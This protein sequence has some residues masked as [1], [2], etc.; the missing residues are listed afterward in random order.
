MAAKKKTKKAAGKKRTAAKKKSPA[1]KSS[2]PDDVYSR[3]R[4]RHQQHGSRSRFTSLEIGRTKLRVVTFHHGKQECAFEANYTHFNVPG[5]RK[6]VRCPGEEADCPIC[7]LEAEVPD[8][9]WKGDSGGRGGI[10]PSRRFVCNAVIRKGPNQKED[11]L[12]QMELPWMV[13]DKINK[14][15]EDGE[16][17][18]AFDPKK[19]VDFH[20]TRSGTGRNTK[21]EVSPVMSSQPVKISLSPVDLSTALGEMPSLRDLTKI[22]DAILSEVE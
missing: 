6:A 12:K 15:I 7:A 3:E 13:W 2:G 16:I 5:E 11:E 21:Y 18:K 19:G 22:A 10:R 1:K 20:V 8:S 9:V 14:A 17:E 4:E